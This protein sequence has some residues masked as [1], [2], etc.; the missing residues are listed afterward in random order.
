[1]PP[2]QV[3]NVPVQN[4]VGNLFKGVNAKVFS[5]L[6]YFEFVHQVMYLVIYL[7]TG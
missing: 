3:E 2:N 6:I 1:M 7:K 5:L 4:G